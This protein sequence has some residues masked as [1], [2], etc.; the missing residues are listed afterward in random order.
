MRNNAEPWFSTS[1]TGWKWKQLQLFLERRWAIPVIIFRGLA[2]LRSHLMQ[3]H[4]LAG[5]ME[6]DEIK[7]KEKVRR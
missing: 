6:I 1:S 5:Y 7:T 2:K 3:N 4:L